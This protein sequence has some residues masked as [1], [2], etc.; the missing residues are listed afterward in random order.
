MRKEFYFN[1]LNLQEIMRPELPLV[2]IKDKLFKNLSTSAKVLYGLLIESFEDSVSRFYFDGWHRIYLYPDV[3]YLTLALGVDEQ[4]LYGLLK[5]LSD[6]NDSGMG[7][8]DV[9]IE[10]ETGDYMVYILNFGEVYEYLK[11]F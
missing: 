6:I 11:E 10:S 9:R 3:D 1:E 8:I 7:L 2:L 5:E 4:T